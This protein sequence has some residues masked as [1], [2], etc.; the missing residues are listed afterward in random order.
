MTADESVI[1][2]L[3]ST[4]ASEKDT[5]EYPLEAQRYNDAIQPLT[6][7]NSQR[8]DIKLRVERLRRLKE[9]IDPLKTSDGGVGIQENLATRNGP[10]EK[11]LERMRMLL[12][13][14]TGRVG[15]LKEDKG[16]NNY[17][18]EEPL[19][20]ARKRNIDDFLADPAVFPGA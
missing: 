14:V 20:V 17:E 10:V 13:R 6:T 2:N 4:W 11:E 15:T 5:T 18:D 8:K 12:I 1:E 19:S 3:P 7:L 16:R 9:T